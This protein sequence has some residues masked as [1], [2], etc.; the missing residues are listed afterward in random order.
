MRAC[1]L[2]VSICVWLA[3]LT[4]AAPTP[5]LRSL[6]AELARLRVQLKHT[7][8][9]AH[10]Q[11]PGPTE[12]AAVLPREASPMEEV[13]VQQH[14]TIEEATPPMAKVTV[15]Q[16]SHVD[17]AQP[18]S[19][20]PVVSEKTVVQEEL[21]Q[22]TKAAPP[23]VGKPTVG[24][25]STTAKTAADNKHFKLLM[26]AGAAGLGIVTMVLFAL[27][28]TMSWKCVFNVLT[29]IGMGFAACWKYTT[30]SFQECAESVVSCLEETKQ[31]GDNCW[32]GTKGC[33]EKCLPC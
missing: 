25:A 27:C 23:A 13:V 17:S 9:E 19:Q 8:S 29:K 15:T 12:R 21:E 33:L 16:R 20:Q 2:L 10:Q 11:L 4:F 30:R 18:E 5:T 7:T 28:S 1:L 22:S 24:K 6:D 14:A 26:W 31:Q 3:A 32:M